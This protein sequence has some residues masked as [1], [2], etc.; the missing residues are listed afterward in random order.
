AGLKGLSTEMLEAAR[1]DGASEWRVFRHVI[2]PALRPTL[3]VVTT[4][5]LINA[6]KVFDLVWVITGGRFGTGVVATLFFKQAFVARDFGVGAALAF[7]LLLAVVPLMAA[8]VR[9][10]QTQGAPV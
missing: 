1:V 2:V 9:R 6:L 4:T 3:I 5:L 7:L 8:S 10:F